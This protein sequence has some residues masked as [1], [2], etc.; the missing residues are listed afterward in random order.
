M[1]KPVGFLRFPSTRHLVRIRTEILSVDFPHIGLC[2]PRTTTGVVVFRVESEPVR[3]VSFGK[4][5]G[6]FSV[7]NYAE[8]RHRTDEKWK[9][10]DPKQPPSELLSPASVV[11]GF[12]WSK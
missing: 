12:L 4:V 2:L 1:G 10:W 9:E 5:S 7:V 8:I 6:G 11:L 3:G